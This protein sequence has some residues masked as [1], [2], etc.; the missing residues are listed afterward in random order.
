M[1][2]SS[3]KSDDA[4]NQTGK[5]A[6]KSQQSECTAFEKLNKTMPCDASTFL[7]LLFSGLLVISSFLTAGLICMQVW[8]YNCQL[9]EMKKSSD[10]ATKA[11]NAAEASV[12]QAQAS[13]HLDQ[14]AWVSVESVTLK[15]PL[16]VGEEPKVTI[17]FRNSG[18]TP[19]QH[20]V[21]INR[22]YVASNRIAIDE[23]RTPAGVKS[24]ATIGPSVPFAVDTKDHPRIE[25][26]FEIEQIKTGVNPLFVTGVIRYVDVFGKPHRTDFTWIFT[27]DTIEQRNAIAWGIGNESD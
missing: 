1:V 15:K 5:E 20:V 12:K 6:D 16:A 4:Q 2:D 7:P 22:V 10:A 13:L 25:N 9:K 23:T 14:R 24:D 11:A 26:Q 27:G 8:I 18:R 19:A 21:F 17:T 3:E